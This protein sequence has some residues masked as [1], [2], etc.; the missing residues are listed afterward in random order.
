MMPNPDRTDL[1]AIPFA[2]AP[3]R[4]QAAVRLAKLLAM[5]DP[6]ADVIEFDEAAVDDWIG[7][8]P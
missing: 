4:W 7:T 2:D 1:P 8:G 3:P 5:L 6:D